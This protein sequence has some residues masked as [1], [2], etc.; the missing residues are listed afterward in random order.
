[1]E[2]ANKYIKKGGGGGGMEYC[3]LYLHNTESTCYFLS[4]GTKFP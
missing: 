4:V 1:M 2:H 3:Y